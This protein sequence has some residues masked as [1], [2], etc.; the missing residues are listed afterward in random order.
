MATVGSI[1]LVAESG[2][3]RF[4]DTN[5][6][7]SFDSAWTVNTNANYS[8]G[9]TRYASGAG[10]YIAFNF[11]GT[12]L[13]FIGRLYNAS[14]TTKASV[15][16]DGIFRGS[17]SQMSAGITNVVLNYELTGLSNSEHSVKIINEDA[18]NFLFDAIDL[19]STAVLKPYSVLHT[20]Y[21]ADSANSRGDRI[22]CRYTASSGSLGIF[23]ELGTCTAAEIPVASTATPDGL[24]YFI[25]VGY[26]KKGNKIFVAD[27]V[28]Q[29]NITLDTLNNAGVASGSG[30]PIT[31]DGNDRCTIRLL[32]GGVSA[33]DKD[34]D[35]DK[36]ICESTLDGLVTAGD[37]NIWNW[38]VPIYQW[39][40]TKLTGNLGVVRG[41][42]S[43]SYWYGGFTSNTGAGLRPV[44]LVD[45]AQYYYLFLKDDYSC[46]AYVDDV[47]IKI[48]D[49]WRTVS[50]V[51][52]KAAFLSAGN[53]IP[54]GLVLDPLGKYKVLAFSPD[55][56]MTKPSCSVSVVPQKR[57]L[58][59][60]GLISLGSFEG[61]DKVTL[62]GSFTGTGTC[63]LLVTSDLLNYKTWNGS[64]WQ[65]V[66][67]DD[68]AAVVANGIS[69][70]ALTDITRQQWDLLTV[71]KTG[72][73]FA[74]LPIIEAVT[75]TC[76]IDKI[77]L[78]VDMK[79]SW[80]RAIHGTDFIYG[81][82][83]NNVLR[84]TLKT[85]GDYKINYSEGVVAD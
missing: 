52:K 62:S 58:K 15:Y 73:G 50:S 64:Q 56:S 42:N 1:L 45:T 69:P 43:S 2:W 7:F 53:N 44:L 47:L 8:G 6:N 5:T 30:L 9:S 32:S 12:K 75:D 55:P 20:K 29:Q 74:Y 37:N 24:F 22:P 18:N 27:R 39:T 46:H 26:D 21:S 4:E 85:N 13:R 82:P 31:I 14:Y 63:K 60:K 35:W 72:I 11:I 17:F 66:D 33:A 41:Y 19:D 77:D 71:G 57:L 34:D 40:S 61:I 38:N 79:G 23:S 48:S 16:V 67:P 25:L 28:I 70:V 51:D 49:D 83:R 78:Q 68:L 3:Q 54:P 80:D 81:Y 36:I 10:K 84:V 65:A 76:A 59:P